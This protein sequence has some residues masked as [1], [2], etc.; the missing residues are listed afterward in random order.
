[1]VFETNIS[2]HRIRIDSEEQFGGT[3]TGPRPKPLLLSAL[4]GCTAMDVISILGKKRVV[5]NTFR[6]SVSGELTE[7]HPKIYKK[8]H[9][10]YEFSG[11]D[12]ENNAEILSKVQRAVQLSLDNYCGI[13]AMLKKACELTFEIRLVNS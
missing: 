13:A 4:S 10:I 9:L 12:F 7:E 8:I 2:G 3:N 5:F 1:M 11:A 6:I